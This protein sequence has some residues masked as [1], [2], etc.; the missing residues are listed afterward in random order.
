MQDSTRVLLSSLSLPEDPILQYAVYS[1][2]SLTDP[3]T[4]LE[5]LRR[6]LLPTSAQVHQEVAEGILSN[7]ITRIHFISAHPLLYIFHVA[8]AN[9]PPLAAIMLDDGLTRELSFIIIL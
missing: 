4:P 6:K 7:L 8:S 1:S 2:S 3:L 9:D 5:S